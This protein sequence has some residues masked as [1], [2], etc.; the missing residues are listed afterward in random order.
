[1]TLICAPLSSRAQALICC[2]LYLFQ[3]SQGNSNESFGRVTN[4]IAYD[5]TGSD[6]QGVTST[7]TDETGDGVDNAST[8]PFKNPQAHLSGPRTSRLSPRW[9]PSGVV[10]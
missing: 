1:M 9:T 6:A 2:V 5:L 10:L 3:S 7:G 8:R 4:R